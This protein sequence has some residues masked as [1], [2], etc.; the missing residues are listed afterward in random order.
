MST[1]IRI[2]LCIYREII[3]HGQRISLCLTKKKLVLF[4]LRAMKRTTKKKNNDV[5]PVTYMLG[6][7]TVVR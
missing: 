5:S 7:L 1:Y 3:A 4:V 6:G 2:V